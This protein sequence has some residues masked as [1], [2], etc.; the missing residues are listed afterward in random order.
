ME[1]GT[2]F[3]K[4]P[5]YMEEKKNG[6]EKRFSGCGEQGK[7]LHKEQ[8]DDDIGR[9]SGSFEREDLLSAG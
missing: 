1:T 6:K 8:E 5:F 3:L 2:K 4:L 7:G 9:C